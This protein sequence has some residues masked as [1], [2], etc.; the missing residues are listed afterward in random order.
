M[1]FKGFVLRLSVLVVSGLVLACGGESEPVSDR[2]DVVLKGQTGTCLKE[3]SGSITQY[4]AG[5]LNESQVKQIWSCLDGALTDFESITSPEHPSGYPPNALARFFENFFAER[6][7]P[8][9]VAQALMNLKRVFVGGEKEFLTQSEILKLREFI[10]RC[11]EWSLRLRPHIPTLLMK[12]PKSINYEASSKAVDELSRVAFEVGLWMESQGQVYTQEEIRELLLSL[13]NWLELKPTEKLVG[14]MVE[15]LPSFFKLKVILIGGSEE[16]MGPGE[17]P[18]FMR[19]AVAVARILEIFAVKFKSNSLSG[20]TKDPSLFGVLLGLE[21]IFSGVNT[22]YSRVHD[23]IVEMSGLSWWPSTFPAEGLSGALKYVIQDFLGVDRNQAN[24]FVD[25][26][27]SFKLR[28]LRNSYS[29][30]IGQSDDEFESFYSSMNGIEGTQGGFIFHE[31]KS[32]AES[33]ASTVKRNQLAFI[34]TFLNQLFKVHRVEDFQMQAFKEVFGEVL[35]VIQTL[36]ILNSV[37]KSYALRLFREIN[38]FTFVSNGDLVISKVETGMYAW[39]ALSGWSQQEWVSDQVGEVC[40]AQD[41]CLKNHFRLDF[42]RWL[43]NYPL[44]SRSLDLMNEEQRELFFDG[45]ERTSGSESLVMNFVVL[46]YIEFFMLRYDVDQSGFVNL[47]E[48]LEAYE[49]FGLTL[50]DLLVSV[51]VPAEDTRAFFTFLFRYGYTPLDSQNMGSLVRYLNW[52]LFPHRWESH[53]NR[54]RLLQILS[55]LS[56]L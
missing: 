48:V 40:A 16:S 20:V 5:D 49:V 14:E 9:E 51:G 35:D 10:A 39:M 32:S 37:E 41:S 55:E 47:S 18:L 54:M 30:F 24:L 45:V 2:V 12:N 27:T 38:V 7:I 50:K 33:E 29:S 34:Y 53:A 3:V 25:D 13:Q 23:L 56:K 4:L 46:T 44:L 26:R 42:S 22:P 28:D 8:L 36:G 15:S 1:S 52:K 31:K 11:Q 21:Q 6:E 17:W 43:F 19:K